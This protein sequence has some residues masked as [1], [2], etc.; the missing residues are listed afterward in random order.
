MEQTV[1][2]TR[3]T[4]LDGGDRPGTSDTGTQLSARYLKSPVLKTMDCHGELI[5]HS[6]RNSQPVQVIMHWP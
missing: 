6:L 4:V 3:Q 2:D 5:L 1:D